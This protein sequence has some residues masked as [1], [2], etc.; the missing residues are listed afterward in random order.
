VIADREYTQRMVRTVLTVTA[1]VLGV[2]AVY[3][4][5][6]ALMLIYV[7]ALIAMGFSPLVRVIERP[8]KASGRRRVP[9]VLAILTI[10]LAI[11]G[12]VVLVGVIVVPPLIDQA[13]TMWDRAPRAFMKLQAVLVRYKL[14]TRAVSLQEAVESAPA[15][16]GG[17]AVGAV[18]LAA[19]TVGG[20][21][22]GIIMI[23]ILSFYLLI[24]AEPLF[25]YFARF[26]PEPR[27]AHVTTA[28][29]EVVAKVSAWLRAQ[30]ILAGV[31]GTFA[32]IGLGLMGEPFFY[33]VA[34]V[35]AIGE[36][37]P[38]VGPII[39]GIT[40]VVVAFTSSPKL[41]LEVGIYFLVLHQLE[42]NILVPKIMEKRVGVSPVTV[43]VAL[44]IG[45]ALWGIV[46][47]IL[48][49]PTAAI[50]SVIVD[51]LTKGADPHIVSAG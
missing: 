51:E 14:L 44:L 2:G 43:L 45:G 8:R 29:R 22:F 50:L 21:I 47:A 46:G 7:S 24:E 10:Y 18:L 11:V 41:A 17:N 30:M 28:S 26:V 34:L 35:A 20:G 27:R 33:V 37:I 19:W 42:A 4:A 6:E 36:T 49:I 16:S 5:R 38:V 32:A 12:V 25:K 48:A 31:M 39:G 13:I 1:V 15:G 3:A 40:A 9:R 23:L